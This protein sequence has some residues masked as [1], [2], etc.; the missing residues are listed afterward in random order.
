METN[1]GPGRL[2]ELNTGLRE[3]ER[4]R[5]RERRSYVMKPEHLPF[6]HSGNPPSLIELHSFKYAG[7]EGLTQELFII[8]SVAPHWQNLGQALN[9]TADDIMKIEHSRQGHAVECCKELLSRW[10][11]GAVGDGETV[12][13]ERLL[14]AMED[15]RCSALAQQL[16]DILSDQGNCMGIV[17]Q[18]T[19]ILH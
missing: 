14:G 6:L 11:Q 8:N 10:L 2:G 1:P 9:F 3:R 4:E 13:W 12:T 18:L 17:S 7:K 19:L 5:E 15:A 16:R